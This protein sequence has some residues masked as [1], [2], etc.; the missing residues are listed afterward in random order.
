[1]TRGEKV[2][3]KNMIQTMKKL[4]NE[5]ENQ[6]WHDECTGWVDA[7]EWVLCRLR[8]DKSQD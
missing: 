8:F 7:L 6:A 3:I 5:P 2:I 4:R 1:M